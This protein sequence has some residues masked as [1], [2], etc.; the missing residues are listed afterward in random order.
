MD[1]LGS[2]PFAW[3][4]SIGQNLNKLC[5]E[6]ESAGE[7]LELAV[8]SIGDIHLSRI[9]SSSRELV[10]TRIQPG[11][12]VTNEIV[13]GPVSPFVGNRLIQTDIE[14]DGVFPIICFRD[15]L[16]NRLRLASK[17]NGSWQI[18][19]V[20]SGI[21]G[22]GC[23]LIV[24]GGQ[25]TVA[26][27]ASGKLNYATR[28]AVNN[29]QRQTVDSASGKRVG[30]SPDM[31]SDQ[32]GKRVI[33]HRNSSDKVLR[34]TEF[35]GTSWRTVQADHGFFNGGLEPRVTLDSDGNVNAF[36]GIES[37][38]LGAESDVALLRTTGFLNGA[39]SS[40]QVSGTSIGGS[41]DVTSGSQGLV[42]AT[43]Q[44]IRSALFGS[45]DALL[46]LSGG[47]LVETRLENYGPADGRHVFQFI[48]LDVDPF[49][50]VVLG[51]F[52]SQTGFAAAREAR[53]PLLS[54]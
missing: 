29:W 18:E 4:P 35:N 27:E 32:T 20:Q 7:A 30:V 46:L 15:K 36:H 37:S 51:Y 17:I 33:V 31:V 43:R 47:S 41:V 40:S 14:M 13:T 39:Y 21:T 48:R 12:V 6:D 5:L 8:D 26:Y 19:T 44:L 38:S 24:E 54:S 3:T 2:N 16:V 22:D 34:I 10:Y 50:L 52:D 25:V 53:L 45:F 28:I 49:G 42:V 11:G 9:L 1:F 23:S